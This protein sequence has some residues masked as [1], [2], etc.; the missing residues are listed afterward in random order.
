MDLQG[1]SICQGAISQIKKKHYPKAVEAYGG[2]IL[3]VGISYDK[4][5]PAGSRTHT[6]RIER[7]EFPNPISENDGVDQ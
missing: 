7:Y 3:L 2:E 6:C 1:Y 4:G 5:E